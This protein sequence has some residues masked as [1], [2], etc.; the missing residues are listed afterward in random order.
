MVEVH[1]NG[2]I[3]VFDDDTALMEWLDAHA[4]EVREESRHRAKK[5]GKE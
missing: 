1:L 2:L 3:F 5:I 4:I